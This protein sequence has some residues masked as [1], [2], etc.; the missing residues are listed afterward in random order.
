M[1]SDY[2][3][4][5][6]PRMGSEMLRNVKVTTAAVLAAMLAAF[7]L[8]KPAVAETTI[9]W[10]DATRKFACAGTYGRVKRLSDGSLAL[11]YSR[12]GDVCIRETASPEKDWGSETLVARTP[13]YSNTNAEMI[14]PEKGS[15]LFAWN[16]RPSAGGAYFIATII[17]TDGGRT[18]GR[19]ARAYTAGKESGTGCWEPAF[20]LGTGGGVQL[21]FANEAPFPG[22]NTEQEIGMVRSDDAGLTWNGYVTVSHRIGARDGMPVPVRLADGKGAAVAIEENGIEGPFK[23]AIIHG[24]DGEDWSSGPVTGGDL[25]RT[26]ALAGASRLPAS[27]YAGAPYL[28]QLPGGETV[29]SVQSTQGR[30]V[31]SDPVASA[32]MR[33]Y[34][35]DAN[36]EGFAGESEPFP[37]IPAGGNGVWNS[38]AVVD[39]ST[40]MAVSSVRGMGKDGLWTVQGRVHRSPVPVFLAT[41]ATRNQNRR[42]HSVAVLWGASH[43]HGFG[44]AM[45]PNGSAWDLSGRWSPQAWET[46]PIPPVPAP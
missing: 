18:W 10:L 25:R 4:R 12:G 40:V 16:G 38:L 43:L 29:L 7:P 39:D 33:V 21:Y 19:E 17:S 44:G 13:G 27:V 41:P 34:V 30:S 9:T 35:G 14:E 1:G 31:S 20:L 26:A 37:G 2:P 24:R 6:G 42:A 45:V 22:S 11:V 23:P 32:V 28:V 15:L 36:A 5:T 46:L 3:P 8:G